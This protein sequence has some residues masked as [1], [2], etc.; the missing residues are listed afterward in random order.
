MRSFGYAVE[1]LGVMLRTQPNFLVH[2]T[3][4]VVVIVLGIVVRLTA[5]E[6]ALVALTIAVVLVVECLN[7]AVESM[8][9]LVSPGFH[10]LVK[11]A[12]DVSAAAVLIAAA[13]SVTI[14]ALLFFPHVLTF[15]SGR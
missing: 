11:R 7:T 1:G 5:A 15:L 3:A 12:K 9:D 14:A 13:A 8:C 6:F 4:A 10:P 2:L